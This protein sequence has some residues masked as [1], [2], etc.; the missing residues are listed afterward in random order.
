MA[1]NQELLRFRV[2]QM[3]EKYLN[4]PKKFIGDH[5]KTE[6]YSQST[7]YGILKN[8]ENNGTWKR[9]IGTGLEAKIMTEPK[10]RVLKEL[11]D[12]K[13]A[14][15]QGDAAK[16]FKCH[17]TYIGKTLKKLGIKKRKKRSPEYTEDQIN[18]IKSQCRW[19]IRKF[20]DTFYVLD[21]EKYFTLSGMQM[22]GNDIFYAEDQNSTPPEIKFKLKKIRAQNSTLYCYIGQRHLKTVLKNKQIGNQCRS[23]SRTMFE[24]DF[25]SIF[26]EISRFKLCILA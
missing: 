9:K 25:I 14:I 19:I 12:N 23:L 5:F 11:F 1:N 17:R 3:R 13:D 6:G 21:D 20:P 7:I 24:E 18:I 2:V 10:K 16:K 15:S 22:P 4:E 26:E 8:I